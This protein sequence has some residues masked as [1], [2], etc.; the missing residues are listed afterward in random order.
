MHLTRSACH[1]LLPPT[2]IPTSPVSDALQPAASL[3]SPLRSRGISVYSPR[4]ALDSVWGGVNDWLAKGL[5]KGQVGA[6][7]GEKLDTNEKSEGAEGRLIVL[8]EPLPVNQLVDR[9]KKHLGL[10]Q[11][12]ISV[13]SSPFSWTNA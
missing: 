3:T 8:D 12:K 13:T 10:S 11:G 5:G 1:C 9:F 6:L 2:H 7:V 4:S